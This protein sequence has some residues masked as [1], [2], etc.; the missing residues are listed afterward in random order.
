MAFFEDLKKK[1]QELTGVATEKA[2]DI[3]AVA[4]EKAQIVADNVKI[5]AAIA[6][7][8]RMMDKNYR[9]VG[10]WV[11]NEMEGEVPAAVAD[12]VAAI[13]ASQSKIAELEARRP[14][15]TK[16]EETTMVCPKCGA[17]VTTK[18]CPDC[19]KEVVEEAAE[20]AAEA[21]EDTVEM[22]EDIVEEVTA[23]KID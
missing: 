17:R 2:Q 18:F 22:V 12:I 5:S 1:A 13:R 16:A 19:G 23:E 9:V 3:A 21:A 10:E 6:N 20:A 11:V 15:D 4:S 14:S 8:K 7:E